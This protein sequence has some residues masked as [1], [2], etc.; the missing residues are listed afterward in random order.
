MPFSF[1]GSYIFCIYIYFKIRTSTCL[2]VWTDVLT[3]ISRFRIVQTSARNSPHRLLFL[4]GRS[5]HFLSGS[6]GVWEG[7][8]TCVCREKLT[9]AG[10]GQSWNM[11]LRSTDSSVQLQPSLPCPF[12]LALCVENCWDSAVLWTLPTS[13]KSQ[14]PRETV[15]RSLSWSFNC[16]HCILSVI[17]ST[18]NR[19]FRFY[20]V[21][22]CLP[23]KF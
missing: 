1:P 9:L 14:R 21:L 13:Q 19:E 12:A 8:Q 3:N 17:I 10:P 6:G 11:T 15:T 5:W 20:S 23:F 7:N 22:T 18:L 4:P 16:T 2:H